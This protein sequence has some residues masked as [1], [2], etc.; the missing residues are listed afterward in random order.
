MVTCPNCG[1]SN[2]GGTSYCELCGTKIDAKDES[3]ERI[4]ANPA[5]IRFPHPPSTVATTHP[6]AKVA[7]EMI[8]KLTLND[9][10]EYILDG[11]EEFLIGRLD[12]MAGIT[13]EIDLTEADK[14]MVTSRKHS[15][16]LKKGDVY[17]VEDLN[18][19]NFTY[20]NGKI[21]S[22]KTPTIL[23]DGDV[24]RIGKLYLVFS[25]IRKN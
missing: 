16:I 5:L 18:S 21:L 10:I 25:R 13:P 9:E 23:D 14:E 3:F 19:T 7:V 4:I 1:R 2:I 24:I 20:L 22:P 8:G 11:K 12:K 6:M 17:L 15:R